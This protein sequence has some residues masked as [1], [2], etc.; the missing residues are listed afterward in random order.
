MD[1]T[2]TKLT[3]ENVIKPNWA[4]PDGVNAFYTNR[5]NG[6][7]R[8]PYDSFNLATHVGDHSARVEANRSRLP[9]ANKI[10]WLQQVHSSRCIS[11][12]EQY[13]LSG[14]TAK[15]DASMTQNKQLVCAVMTADCLPILITNQAATCVTAVHAGWRGLANGVLQNSIKAM[16]CPTDTLTLWVG[17]HISQQHFEVGEEVKQAFTGYPNAFIH[18]A[19]SLTGVAKYQCSLIEIVTA[20]CES[21]GLSQIHSENICTYQNHQLF[22]SHRHGQHNGAAQTGRFISAIY[23]EK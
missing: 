9:L 14:E 8:Q 5:L 6:V 12:S 11:L 2:K 3:T 21:L 17:P 13:F 19:N 23:L 7:S 16:Q 4:L 10:A 22:Y 15:A 20:I 1:L 18:V